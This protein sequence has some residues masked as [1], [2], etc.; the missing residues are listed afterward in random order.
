MT[1]MGRVISFEVVRSLK[2]RS[3]WFATIVIPLIVIVIGLIDYASAH[4][5]NTTVQSQNQSY[6]QTAKIGIYDQAGL[7]N[8]E[9]IKK[10]NIVS[11]P[12]VQAGVAAVKANK[13]TAFFYY[14]QN[15][16]KEGISVYAQDQGVKFS[17]PYNSA[18]ETLLRESVDLHVSLLTRNHQ[19]AQILEKSPPI[20]DATYKNGQPTK[21]LA[22]I[23]APGIIWITF[24][25][26][27]VMLAY[28]AVV[29]TTEEKENRAAEIL[30]TSIKSR[31][32]ILGKVL[33]IF[34]LALVQVVIIVI[35]LLI[36]YV[37]FKNHITL[38][39]GVALNH[40]PI[41]ASVVVTGFA[42]LLFGLM[43]Y[44]SLLMGFGSLFPSAQEASRYLFII[45]IWS[46]IPIY[47]LAYIV[48]SP[49]SLI[50]QVF[51]YFPL[52]APSTVLLRN[53]VG[54]ISTTDVLISFAI[55]FVSVVTAIAFVV[56][57]FQYGAMQYGR[58][59]SIKELF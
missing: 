55:L 41:S 37:I 47:A 36:A 57:A 30:L 19:I 5:A 33:S 45:I 18:A 25:V 34:I 39:G 28:F 24:L 1:K 58:R 38:P 20:T 40:I 52:T 2:K 31:S 21:G 42:F 46:L 48:S 12:N 27:V 4:N 35:P 23:I 17:P 16:A 11:E 22:A 29:A 3:F 14:P 50:V 9:I 43:L 56:R 26:L 15:V 13:L 44:I 54:T 59:I 32:L 7:I 53:A 51:T 10:Q 8:A 49:H 6:F